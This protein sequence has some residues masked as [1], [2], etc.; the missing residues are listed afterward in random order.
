MGQLEPVQGRHGGPAQIPQ[1]P[2]RTAGT[3]QGSENAAV[4]QTVGQPFDRGCNSLDRTRFS[5]VASRGLQDGSE[6]T[7]STPARR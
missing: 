3:G 5:A 6:A 4:D 2:F 1:V 7:G